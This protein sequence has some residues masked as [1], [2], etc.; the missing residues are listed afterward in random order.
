MFGRSKP[1]VFEPYGGRRS[2][3]R[4]PRWLILLVIGIAIG[5]AGVIYVQERHLPPRLSFDASTK[6]RAS[7]EQAEQA[8]QRLQQE[9]AETSKQL[10]EALADKQKLTEEVSA[11][12]KTIERLREDVS[13]AV[14]ALPP[15]PRG[16]TI[17][18]RAARLSK[19]GSALAYDVV[20]SRPNT[21]GK[22]LTGVMQLV[23]AGDSTRGGET[24]VSLPPVNVSVASYQTL[25]GTLPL[26]EGFA[27]KQATIN[28]LDRPDGKQLGMRVIYVK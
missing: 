14:A 20:L 1:V 4:V 2:R 24:T 18:I 28:V 8:R 10:E 16:G 22:P 7:F 12:L 27:P 13:F 17:E 5:V 11:N 19:E 9:L 26:P 6:L 21:R 23:V 15:D 3:K 25:S